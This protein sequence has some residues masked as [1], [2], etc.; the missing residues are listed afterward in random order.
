MAFLPRY[1]CL[2]SGWSKFRI[3]PV[4][5]V[6]PLSAFTLRTVT[7]HYVS[8]WREDVMT[9]IKIICY[10]KRF[11][12]P[13]LVCYYIKE[14][15]HNF[16]GMAFS[17]VY[18]CLFTLF[19]SLCLIPNHDFSSDI[20]PFFNIHIGYDHISLEQHAAHCWLNIFEQQGNV[21]IATFRGYSMYWKYPFKLHF[22]FNLNLISAT[23]LLDQILFKTNRNPTP[24]SQP[25]PSR[26][27]LQ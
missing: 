10:Q 11:S 6:W 9:V 8:P 20:F 18:S 12:F 7:C 15:Y 23:R 13:F 5:F 4:I 3:E 25:L 27:P 14:C 1:F 19:L 17:E 26:P 21:L 24:C 2:F 16:Q 22:S